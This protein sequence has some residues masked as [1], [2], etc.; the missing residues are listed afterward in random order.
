MSNTKGS[1]ITFVNGCAINR[2]M[3]YIA[4]SPDLWTESEDAP[5][6]VMFIYQDQT[7][8]KWFYHELP[9]WEVVSTCF[10][11]PMANET[12][13][14]YAL[15]IDGEVECYSRDGTIIEVIDDAGDKE[16]GPNYGPVNRIRKLGKHL[17][18]CGHGGQ[19]YRRVDT[20]WEHCDAGLLQAPVSAQPSS[21]IT[22]EERQQ[23]IQSMIDAMDHEIALY[24]INGPNEDDLYV[25]GSD[26]FIAHY[27]GQHWSRLNRVTGSHLN[28]IHVVSPSELWI[29]GSVGTV[30]RGNARQGFKVVARKTSEWDFLS[31]TS[32][33]GSIYIAADDGIYS[34]R[35]EK[36]E[37]LDISDKLNLRDVSDIEAK[38]GVLWAL[39]PKKLLRFDG[40][41]WE[42]FEHPNNQ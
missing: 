20:G 2:D 9:N 28:C 18:V 29:A 11:E 30:L 39:S 34:M 35:N 17:Y 5:Y 27:D 14:A 12:R 32:Y 13:K 24:D 41:E 8:E 6:S 37:R 23:M 25:V 42:C 22:E 10:P 1:P 31:I 3:Y 40:N 26:G 38:D 15:N 4:S 7:E 36:P 33:E 21:G 16:G 19:V